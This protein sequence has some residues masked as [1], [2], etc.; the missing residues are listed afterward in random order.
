MD[1]AL[2]DSISCPIKPGKKNTSRATE[3]PFAQQ[4]KHDK[5]GAAAV[6]LTDEKRSVPGAA[7]RG[8]R[9]SNG[10]AAAAAPAEPER[11]VRIVGK[12]DP[13]AARML[14]DR[15]DA[16]SIDAPGSKKRSPAPSEEAPP[17]KKSVT[18]TPKAPRANDGGRA[19]SKGEAAVVADAPC[20]SENVGEDAVEAAV[21]KGPTDDGCPDEE[22]EDQAGD[23]EDSE[24]EEPG[25][26][27][28]GS[29]D[30]GEETFQPKVEDLDDA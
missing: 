4:G 30:E 13:A 6:V 7:S 14:E 27:E 19:A 2:R 9:P 28:D 12:K 29:E 16:S 23:E 8:G 21:S 1:K 15:K 10:F 3:A 18:P 20:E 25:E 11:R 26:K 5:P 24:E 17:S 22:E